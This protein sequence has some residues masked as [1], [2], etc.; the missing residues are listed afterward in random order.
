MSPFA[1]LA[2]QRLPELASRYGSQIVYW[3]INLPMA[4]KAAGNTGP[5]NVQIPPKLR[6]LMKDLGRWA[7]RYGVPLVFP[8]SL[9][10]DLMNKGL[11]YAIDMGQPH[12]YTRAAWHTCWG[13]GG[14]P[15]DESL[16]RQ[17]AEQLG[18]PGN[19]FLSYLRSPD[20]D[21]RYAQTNA[22]AHALG[23]FGVPTMM[24]GDN[25]WWGNDRLEFLEEFLQSSRETTVTNQ[26]L[27]VQV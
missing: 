12:E 15:A 17:V 3:P 14:D 11:F 25:M 4:K 22:E 18:W 5:P 8:K 21:R 1:Y 10:S 26:A 24:I 20:A 2:Y 7:Q 23:V 13:L 6:Y 19:G 9:D 27:L 16:L